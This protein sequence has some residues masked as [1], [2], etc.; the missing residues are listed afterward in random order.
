MASG[1]QHHEGDEAFPR[2]ASTVVHHTWW[3]STIKWPHNLAPPGRLPLYY[4][5]AVFEMDNYDCVMTRRY[6]DENTARRGHRRIVKHI[7][8]EGHPS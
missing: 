4:E 2:V 5:T 8:K 7:R 1:A 3:V 6:P